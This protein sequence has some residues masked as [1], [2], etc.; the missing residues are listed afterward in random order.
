MMKTIACLIASLILVSCY[1]Q[2]QQTPDAWS[3]TEEQQDSIS[4]Y[5]THHYTQNYNFL[6]KSDSLVLYNPNMEQQADALPCLKGDSLV[7]SPGS[8]VVVADIAYMPNDTIDSVWVKLA[9]DQNTQGWI[10][11]SSM[12]PNVKPDD[13]I[14]WFIDA[15]SDSHLLLFLA[16]VVMVLAAYGLLR[17]KR[18][19]A[20]IIHWNDI[21]SPLP[22]MLALTVS[23]AAVLYA[24]I[25]RFDPESWRHFYYHPSLNPFSLPPKLSLFISLVWALLI[26]GVAVVDDVCRRFALGESLLYL[27]GVAAVCAVDYVVFSIS[28]LYYV[29]YPL[30]I[31]YVVYAVY[32]Y[33]KQKSK[34]FLCGN[35]GHPIDRLGECPYCG[36][37]NV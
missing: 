21:D 33:R 6:V 30:F 23:L 14:S 10:H 19:R 22:M 5:T 7:V 24:S 27:M 15:F 9:Y 36:A 13:P 20:L 8:M 11:E 25:Q 29:G 3:L 16:L 2:Y 17:L 4:F 34:P 35:C 37:D 12:L 1:N 28:T 31:V 32:L 26:M 18:R